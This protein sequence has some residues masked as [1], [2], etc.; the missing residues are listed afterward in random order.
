MENEDRIIYCIKKQ[1]LCCTPINKFDFMTFGE[2]GFK[3]VDT[4]IQE[5]LL[6]STVNNPT[7]KKYPLK[8]SYQKAFLK[9]IIDKL[10]RCNQDIHDN[11]YDLY[12]NLVSQNDDSST[13]YRH[14]LLN[15]RATRDCITLEESTSIISHGTTG[16][17]SWQAALTLAEWCISNESQLTGKRILELGSGIGL[18]GVAVISACSPK[19]YTFSDCHPAV[20]NLLCKN[21]YTNLSTDSKEHPEN[22]EKR[23]ERLQFRTRYKDSGVRVEN[24]KWEEIEEYVNESTLVPEIVIAADVL[25]DKSNFSALSNALE[26]LLKNGTQYAIIAATVRN[27]STIAQFL[28]ELDSKLGYED[29][30]VPN[31]EVFIQTS[32]APIRIIRVFKELS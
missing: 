5:K 30:P 13:H 11:V 22:L 28:E 8:K 7:V 24:L 25:Y 2:N 29:E 32:D 3:M 14:F 31:S 23:D 17:C 6:N 18:T 9:F 19:Q 1:F 20:L 27:S 21:L 4:C 16:M 15:D 12:C 26:T 10:E